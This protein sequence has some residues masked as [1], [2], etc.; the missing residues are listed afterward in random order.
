M[1]RISI[2]KDYEKVFEFIEL[3]KYKDVK[4]MD[5]IGWCN[6]LVYRHI[7]FRRS[8][9]N[10]LGEKVVASISLSPLGHLAFSDDLIIGGGPYSPVNDMNVLM[11]WERQEIIREKLPHFVPLLEKWES[12]MNTPGPAFLPD[13][14]CSSMHSLFLENDIYPGSF[15]T[16]FVEVDLGASDEELVDGLKVWLSEKRTELIKHN[17]QTSRKKAFTQKDCQDWSDKK[18]LEYLDILIFSKFFGVN[19]PNHAIGSFLF[20]DEYDT[21]LSERVRKVIK[22]L[23]ESLM[24]SETLSSL[25]ISASSL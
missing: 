17:V 4:K 5:L 1:A 13:E 11:S 12:A 7:L 24:Q 19:P 21:D 3:D 10:D 25:Q 8:L 9:D 20:P 23:A 18:V 14:L 15:K 16:A 22:P 6:M 2:N